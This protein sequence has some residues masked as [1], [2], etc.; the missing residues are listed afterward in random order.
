M[1]FSW[2]LVGSLAVLG[3]SAV[4]CDDNE[5]TT[6]AGGGG[7]GG[8]PSTGGGGADGGGGS[9]GDT[10][11]GGAGGGSGDSGQLRVAHLSPGTPA[12]DV[13][14]LPEG[15][16][17]IGPVLKSLGDADGLAFPEVTGYLPLP[18]G[19]YGARIV[20]PNA[21]DCTAALADLP[22]I[23]GIEVKAGGVYTA[24]A[25]GV[26][27]D[28]GSGDAAFAV[29]LYEDDLTSKDDA[30]RVRFI[31]ASPDTPPVDV[32]LG[33]ADMFTPVWQNVSFPEI[34]L[35]G[36][37]AYLETMPLTDATLSARASGTD[38]DAIV[39]PGV[40]IPGG[41]VVTAFAIGNLDSTPAPLKV[42]VC[43]DNSGECVT[44]P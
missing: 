24:A 25:T 38:M 32:G 17:P 14:V 2:I 28:P 37:N 31:H 16:A 20:A 41:S 9:G 22:D 12:V 15:G 44:L 23:T 6:D 35:V 11:T 21:A 5:G 40:T 30:I 36:G 26:L 8:S 34:G 7:S 43:F 39:I 27:I 29:E 3:L 13:C 42:R 18:A 4:G 33:M 1:R 10:T 19:K